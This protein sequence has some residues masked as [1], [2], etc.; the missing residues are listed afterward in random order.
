MVTKLNFLDA[1][2]V[3]STLRENKMPCDVIWMD[4]DYKDGLA[5]FTFDQV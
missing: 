5:Y 3:A 4:I 1:V 2:Q